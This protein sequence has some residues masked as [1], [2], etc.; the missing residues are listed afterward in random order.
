MI[1]LHIFFV[2]H[3]FKSQ[4]QLLQIVVIPSS[5]EYFLVL[6]DEQDVEEQ[7]HEDEH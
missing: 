5:D 3:I 1:V 4:I 6:T 7:K 2:K